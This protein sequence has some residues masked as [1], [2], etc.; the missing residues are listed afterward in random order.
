MTANGEFNRWRTDQVAVQ[1]VSSLTIKVRRLVEGLLGG[2]HPSIHF[3]ASV[4]FADHKKY[5]PGD[6]IRHIDWNAL[7]RTDRYF[8]KQQQRE[9]ILNALLVLDC[10][11]SMGYKGSRAETNKL[12]YAAELLGAMAYI[13]VHQGDAAGLLTFGSTSGTYV[14]SGRRP[15]QLALLMQRLAHIQA[16]KG[17][18]TLYTEAVSKAASLA[19]R[20]ALIVFVTDLW[21][22]TKET[23]SALTML[24]ARGHDIALMHLLDPDETDLP[25]THPVRLVGM[26]GE[27]EEIVDPALIREDFRIASE[28]FVEKWRLFSGRHGIDFVTAQTNRKASV[29]LSEFAAKRRGNRRIR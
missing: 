26:E 21:G 17:G 9:V 16:D 20:R 15:D 19:G 7:A 2:E 29:V 6:D 8:V 13:I 18:A 1:A 14:P 3:G 10:S 23:E 5:N 25:F 24:A 12:G 27:G 22:A 4:E 28:R 11:A